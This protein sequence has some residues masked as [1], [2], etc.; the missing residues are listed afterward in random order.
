MLMTLLGAMVSRAYGD[1][2]AL[3]GAS[4]LA[5][6]LFEWASF[7]YRV[8]FVLPG[9]RL[10][11]EIR[12]ERKAVPLLWSGGEFDT[13][14]ELLLPA[15]RLP[16][17][18]LEDCVPLVVT[19]IGGS[20]Q[21]FTSVTPKNPGVVE[22]RIRCEAP[23][24]LIFEGVIVRLTD[25]QGFFHKRTLLK[26]GRHYPVLPR[27]TGTEGNRRGTKRHNIFPPPGVHRL[28]QPGGGTELHDL[29]DY[30]PGDPPKMIAWKASA[31]KDKLITK[32]FETEVPVR[33]TLFVDASESV[34]VGPV[35]KSKLT[36]LANLAAGVAEGVAVDRDHVGL[37]IFD[38]QG[39]QMMRPN[40]SRTHLIDMLHLLAKAAARP[41]PLGPFADAEVLSKLAFP[42]A[43]ELYPELMDRRVNR[44]PLSMFWNPISDTRR[45]WLL[46]LLFLPMAFTVMGL[47]A[48]CAGLLNRTL[49]PFEVYWAVMGPFVRNI[50][51]YGTLT[52]AGILAQLGYLFWGIHGIT[53]FFGEGRRRRLRRKQLGLLFATL[54][55]DEAG[56]EVHYLHDDQIFSRRAM[57]FLADH[58]AR[59]PI[60][61]HDTRGRYLFHSRPKLTTLA[62]ALNYGVSRGRDNELFVLLADLIDLAEELDPVL[63]AVRVAVG[64]HHQ[65]MII[66]P[67]QEDM[68][69]P[70]G[71][72]ADDS[73][74]IP[75]AELIA[76]R[77]LQALDRELERDQV[78]RYHKNFARVRREFGRL[79][80]TV[81]RAGHEET[82]Q[83]VLDRMN[84]LRGMAVRR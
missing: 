48:S 63:Q 43:N 30:M 45:V 6:F 14:V 20:E 37:V 29:R 41:T 9:L 58:Q 22:Y 7:A 34:R 21:K 16:D 50:G 32:E 4:L 3:V 10:R 19:K 83:L 28:R 71:T 61:L 69:P 12:D 82:V 75:K 52:A 59:Y 62:G 46:F 68:P 24:E 42:M 70:A 77:G 74:R 31:R 33:A 38:E 5:W 15:G 39:S 57:R 13:R 73:L 53:G 60:R 76:D 54:D 65:V 67:W 78:E 36:R 25:R 66:I 44:I 27:L 23:G 51:V 64:R 18:F 47:I 49:A 8:F 26:E 11:R 84:R 72:D 2:M 55:G 80:V 17:V 40:R 1:G 79:G 81:V 56:A 35:S